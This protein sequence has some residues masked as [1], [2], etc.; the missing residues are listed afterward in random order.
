MRFQSHKKRL[1]NVRGSVDTFELGS[2]VLSEAYPQQFFSHSPSE[3]PS[4]FYVSVADLNCFSFAA[5]MQHLH[6]S[7]KLMHLAFV[8]VPHNLSVGNRN[9]IN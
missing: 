9:S 1:K 6:F 4:G 3:W 7:F 2:L 5:M 8:P